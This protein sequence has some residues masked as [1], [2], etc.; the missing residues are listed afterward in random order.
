MYCCVHR[1]ALTQLHLLSFGRKIIL[2]ALCQLS[3]QFTLDLTCGKKKT[4]KKK[5][6]CFDHCSQACNL[7]HSWLAVMSV[8]SGSRAQ[9]TARIDINLLEKLIDV[10]QTH[11]FWRTV[12]ISSKCCN[13]TQEFNWDWAAHRKVASLHVKWT[14]EASFVSFIQI[15]MHKRKSGI[16]VARWRNKH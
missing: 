14:R 8:G 9:T 13:W 15:L 6:S 10:V 16:W 3:I 12:Q 5:N 4:K 7:L 11:F 2:Q 1:L